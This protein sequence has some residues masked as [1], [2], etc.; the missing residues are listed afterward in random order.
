MSTTILTVVIVESLLAVMY[1][2][3]AEQMLMAEYVGE[4]LKSPTPIVGIAMVL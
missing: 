3:M 2:L 4:N 1:S